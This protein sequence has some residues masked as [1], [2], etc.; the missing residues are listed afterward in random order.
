MDRRYGETELL[1]PAGFAFNPASFSS[2]AERMNLRY[3]RSR[4]ANAPAAF[5]L[6]RI[7][8][9]R[10]ARGAAAF[11]LALA[12]SVRK[13]R[14]SENIAIFDFELRADDM[15]HIATLET[16]TS[17]FFSHRDPAIVQWMSERKL[18]I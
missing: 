1:S 2:I 13:E 5:W 15:A 14:M 9:L 6:R 12:K 10:Q 18:D 4:G 11:C 8:A 17:S 7:R 16:G 3:E